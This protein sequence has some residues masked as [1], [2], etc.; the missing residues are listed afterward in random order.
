MSEGRAL[1]AR[2]SCWA[3]SAPTGHFLGQSNYFTRIA[4]NIYEAKRGNREQKDCH[5]RANELFRGRH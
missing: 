5:Y 1:Y 3:S 2:S 4:I